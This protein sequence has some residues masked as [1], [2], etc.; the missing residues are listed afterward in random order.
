M[1]GSWRWLTLAYCFTNLCFGQNPSE[2]LEK[3]RENLV[4]VTRN[5]PKYTCV[6]TIDRKYFAA[7]TAA[8]GPLLKADS[9]AACPVIVT[10]PGK[11]P[12]L[13]DRLRLEVTIADGHEIHAWPGAT[14]FDLR[15]IDE[16]VDGPISTGGFGAYL[17][18]IF[19]NPGTHFT[20]IGQSRSHGRAM[21]EYA[22]RV[23]LG[24]PVT[25]AF[26]KS[27]GCTGH[28]GSFLID[29]ESLDL[30]RLRIQTDPVPPETGMCQSNSTIE[31]HRLPIGDGNLVLPTHSD[32]Q[33]VE[34]GS[35]LSI[36]R[37]T[38]SA[39]HEFQ[40]ESSIHFD[41][42]PDAPDGSKKP[43]VIFNA[44]ASGIH[45]GVRTIS[46][47]SM[48]ESAAGDRVSAR[49]FRTSNNKLLP[50]G[51]IVSGRI[52]VLRHFPKVSRFQIAIALDTVVI[53]NVSM[54]IVAVIDRAPVEPA[55]AGY[56]FKARPADLDFTLLG[57]TV[58]RGTFI[59]PGNTKVVK[60]GFEMSW[61]TTVP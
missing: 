56:G 40:A 49:V 32:L 14:E 57:D 26:R 12:S 19:D 4:R 61:V 8:A 51:A 27:E 9:A 25:S 21:L 60:A 53:D 45:F 6:E 1:L 34:P 43:A 35:A 58:Y 46:P 13:T 28:A 47:V 41:H 38:Y 23:E 10:K 2:I 30:A 20:Y 37:T 22:Y 33:I 42:D 7:V 55:R 17:I 54:P 44:L 3:A 11:T 48:T 39:C 59:F 15:S 52:T 18:E 29:R 31:Y 24:S 36:A 5:I 16:I 50:E